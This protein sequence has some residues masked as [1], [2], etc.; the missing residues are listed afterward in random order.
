[1]VF[2]FLEFLKPFFL[3]G[4][5]MKKKLKASSY[6]NYRPWSILVRCFG[7]T[8][9]KKPSVRARYRNPDSYFII[10]TWVKTLPYVQHII[11][12]MHNSSAVWIAL[13]DAESFYS[14]VYQILIPYV[15]PGCLLIV[16]EWMVR[17]KINVSKQGSI[18]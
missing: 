11:F 2:Q 10:R 14:I 15:K 12:P 9:L 17:K 13:L 6:S 16:L 18:L 1:M 7:N 4:V 3:K 8:G 5:K